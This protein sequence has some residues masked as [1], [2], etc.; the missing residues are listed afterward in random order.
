M[1]NGEAY[2]SFESL[3]LTNRAVTRSQNWLYIRFAGYADDD[4]RRGFWL[5]FDDKRT[6]KRAGGSLLVHLREKR[7]RDEITTDFRYNQTIY[8]W[9]EQLDAGGYIRNR[10]TQD[11]EQTEERG[12]TDD[13]HQSITPDGRNESAVCLNPSDG[14]E[15]DSQVCGDHGAEGRH[16]SRSEDTARDGV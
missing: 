7:A 14:R 4:G 2:V 15:H 9:L 10:K 6:A 13:R 16:T 3:L 5:E 8:N 11:A 12:I 1:Q